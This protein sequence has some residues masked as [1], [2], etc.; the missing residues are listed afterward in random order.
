MRWQKPA[1]VVLAVAGLGAAA[2]VYFYARDRPQR[3]PAEKPVASDRNAT[4]ESG[5]G[6]TMRFSGDEK[7]VR[8][9]FDSFKSYPDKEVLTKAHAVFEADGLELWADEVEFTKKGDVRAEQFR[10]HGNVRLRTTDGLELQTDSASYDP[11]GGGTLLMPGKVTFSKGRVSGSGDGASY[12]RAQEL[13]KF[14]ENANVV[15]QPDEKGAGGLRA[16][17]RSMT[18]ARIEHFA[19]L[20]QGAVIERTAETLSGDTATIYLTEDEKQIR[21]V[22][23][24]GHAK[25]TPAPGTTGSPDM[26]ADTISLVLHPEGNTL[27]RSTL[28][29]KAAL[30]IA[31]A[32]GTKSITAAWIDAT[33][34]PD[35]RTLTGL[36]A[37]EQVVV[38]LPAA[39]KTPARRIEAATLTSSGDPKKGLTQA[40][41]EGSAQ[42]VP[43][44][45]TERHANSGA[46]GATREGTSRRL[47]L[48]L[49]GALDAIDDAEFREQ[50]RFTARDPDRA[51]GTTQAQSERAVYRAAA[52]RLE[53]HS[54]DGRVPHVE[55]TDLTVD[56]HAIN[57]EIGA[58]CMDATGS[59]RTLSKP[60]GREKS[61]RAGLFD[62]KQDVIGAASSLQYQGAKGTATY[63]GAAGAPASLTQGTSRISSQR[64]DL[65]DRSGNLRAK[66]GVDSTMDIE[67]KTQDGG[68]GTATT[69]ARVAH[70]ITSEE[71]VYDDATRKAVYTGTAN[72]PAKLTRSDG[73]TEAGRIEIILAPE[74]RTLRQLLAFTNVYAKLDQDSEAMGD[75]LVY[76]AVEELYTL[77]GSPGQ[78]AIAKFPDEE[79]KGCWKSTGPVIR[80]KRSGPQPGS[81]QRTRSETIDCKVSI[82]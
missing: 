48:K 24:T 14:N 80:F 16:R 75:R 81:D 79:R 22:D 44:R 36:S 29:G 33:T 25:V 4:V 40:R 60:S 19:R 73:S 41:F 32:T 58:D 71:L 21:L 2:A 31:E 67:D 59:V 10:G 49:G 3:A 61:K 6:T 70:R 37:R 72:A 62:D 11:V 77:Y 26:G 27:Q 47:D 7:R 39:Q 57:L 65:D 8:Y 51:D 38:E 5:P 17:S 56:A 1:R 9:S 74:G 20:E 18:L 34:A 12:V 54:A 35:G 76:D 50:V 82:R 63:T 53:L 52:D 43:V 45:F 64:I 69:V 23:L 66:G 46:R 55:R 68:R 30:A 28:T 15:L 13:F 78:S 42:G